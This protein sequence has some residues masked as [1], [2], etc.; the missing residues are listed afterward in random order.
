[1]LGYLIQN[2]TDG[3]GDPSARMAALAADLAAEGW[4]LAGAVQ[5]NLD[6]RT[7]CA[8][9]MELSVLGAEAAP[10]RISQSLG[11]GSSGCRLDSDALE[12]AAGLAE[13]VLAERG[14]G[15]DLVIV[16]KFG[17]QEAAGRGFRGLI[18]AALAEDV[19][20]LTAVAPDQLAGFLE[21]AGD[22]ATRLD[23]ETAAAWCRDRRAAAA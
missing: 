14:A 22:Y 5:V 2:E 4:R 13:R 23:W 15:V 6:R 19:P 7:D 8:C 20:V 9:D 12:R 17:K 11:A 21:F 10:I 3:A 18:G 1:M 16:N